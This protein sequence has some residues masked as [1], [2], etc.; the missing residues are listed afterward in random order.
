[1]LLAV[2]PL[3]VLAALAIVQGGPWPAPAL[4]CVPIA[5]FAL[6]AVRVAEW[7]QRSIRGAMLWLLL[8]T[9]IYTSLLCVARGRWPEALAILAAIVPARL[10]ARAIALT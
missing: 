7:N 5:A 8:G 3:A 10:I 9:M 2:P 1:S 6:R 4:A